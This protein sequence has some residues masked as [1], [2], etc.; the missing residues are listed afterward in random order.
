[1]HS[2][3]PPRPSIFMPP[4]TKFKSG[5]RTGKRSCAICG[6]PPPPPP[7]PPRL[8]PACV[9]E[10]RYRLYTDNISI[11]RLPN[12]LG[13]SAE[14]ANEAETQAAILRMLALD[15]RCREAFEGSA[16]G[17]S[18]NFHSF[19]ATLPHETILAVLRYIG[20]SEE[21][22]SIFKRF[23]RV[24]LNMGPAVRGASDQVRTCTSGVPIPHGFDTFFGEAVMFCLDMAVHQSTRSQETSPYLLRIRD[25]CHFVGNEEQCKEAQQQIQG[26]ANIMALDVDVK[27]LF[28][29]A[30]GPGSTIGFVTFHRNEVQGG[31]KP[32]QVTFGIDSMRVASSARRIK[33]EL[34]DCSTI[35]EWVRVWN[36]TI[37]TYAP[38]LFGPL[39]TVFGQAHLEA[40]TE[41]YN[42]AHEII[43]DNNTT[44]T[45]RVKSLLPPSLFPVDPTF[46]LDAWIHLP[47]AYGG[48]GVKNPY[49]T[50]NN[51]RPMLED[52]VAL[53]QDYL[54]DE[55]KYY[56]HVADRFAKLTTEQRED[57][58]KD[59]FDGDG[60]RIAKVFGADPLD[61][62]PRFPSLEQLT[63]HRQRLPYPALPDYAT[64]TMTPGTYGMPYPRSSPYTLLHRCGP[65]HVPIPSHV[66]FPSPNLPSE[67]PVS[68]PDLL[69]TYG[70]LSRPL[71]HADRGASKMILNEVRRL[72][73][74]LGMRSW[75]EMSPE[76]R[77]AVGFYGDECFERFGGLEMWYGEGVPRELLK[78]VRRYDADGD[79]GYGDIG[80]NP[81]DEFWCMPEA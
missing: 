31:A 70:I 22:L 64:P 13:C 44:L 27:D 49:A 71:Y 25:E 29:P 10:A 42:L 46:S 28:P 81:F 8:P 75:Y 7:P 18:A 80:G 43:F 37:G 61:K 19:A 59:I 33:Q 39:V 66:P 57:K 6:P 24:P 5:R 76:E 56:D 50:L 21:W 14:R 40:V 16:H 68:S 48:L 47:V 20:I 74:K 38:G 62:E 36:R 2:P 32:G 69:H 63:V 41:A 15:I 58:L 35:F 23:L 30:S 51:V 52:P 9:D 53:L 4:P 65:S 77:W 54:M 78:A 11:S 17:I 1:M 45:D 60:D 67:P 3:P 72:S 26:F 55:S 73:G 79:A 34:A 12:R